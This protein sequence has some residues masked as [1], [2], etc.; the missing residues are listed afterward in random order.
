MKIMIKRPVFIITDSNIDVPSAMYLLMPCNLFL[1]EEK[2]KVFRYVS[3][4]SL[5]GL[6]WGLGGGRGGRC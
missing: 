1:E 4:L 3:P 6:S 5:D 2:S